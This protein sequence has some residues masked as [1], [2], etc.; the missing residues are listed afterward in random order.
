[1]PG[2]LY[3]AEPECLPP[4]LQ[5]ALLRLVRKRGG[6][7][8]RMVASARRGLQKLVSAGT[9]STEL[10]NAL[11]SFRIKVPSLRDRSEDIPAL[12]SHFIE[13]IAKRSGS[14]PC[15]LTL[16]LFDAARKRPWLGNLLELESAAEGL[17]SRAAEGLLQV[18]DLDDILKFVHAEANPLRRKEVSQRRARALLFTCN[19]D[20][21]RAAQVLGVSRSSMYRMLK[22]KSS[23]QSPHSTAD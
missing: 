2:M 10:A 22:Q 16:E 15:Q 3:L 14:T 9:I 11:G 5:T 23:A 20:T 4:A 6:H 7:A 8:P 1:M 18:A 12:L 21:L 13:N 19:G 17:M